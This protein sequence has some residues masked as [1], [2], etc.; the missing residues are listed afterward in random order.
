MDACPCECNSGGFCGGCGHAGCG[1]RARLR[2]HSFPALS[3]RLDKPTDFMVQ[4]AVE[5]AHDAFGYSGPAGAE[6]WLRELYQLLQRR[7]G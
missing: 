1:M 7:Y 6:Q 2:G 4:R 3:A 5:R